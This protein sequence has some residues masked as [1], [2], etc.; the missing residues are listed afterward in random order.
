MESAENEQLARDFFGA[1]VEGD[2]DKMMSLAADDL[3]WFETALYGRS[4]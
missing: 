3:T 4:L 1:L 2:V